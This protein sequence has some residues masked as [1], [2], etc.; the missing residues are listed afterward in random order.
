[1]ILLSARVQ[2]A[3]VAQGLGVG[4]DAYLHKPFTAQDLVGLVERVLA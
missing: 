3:E 4:A 2:E 1:V